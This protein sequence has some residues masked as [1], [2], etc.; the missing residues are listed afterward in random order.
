MEANEKPDY[1]W[2]FCPC[3]NMFTPVGVEIVAGT[4]RLAPMNLFLHN[5]GDIDSDNNISPE[6][7]L[8]AASAVYYD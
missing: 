5:I 6:D 8:M 7:E 2:Y 1:V 3:R 4:R